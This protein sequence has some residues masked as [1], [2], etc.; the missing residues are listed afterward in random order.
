MKRSVK[1]ILVI[2][3]LVL[4]FGGYY[5]YK[6]YQVIMGSE[7]LTGELELIPAAM[8]PLPPVTKENA[9]WPNWRGASFEG[10][11]ETTGT[12]TDWSR[13]LKKLWQVNYLCQDKSTASWS[14][15]VVQGNRLIVPGRDEKN[16]LLFCINAD[17]GE[18]IWLGSYEAETG[19]SHGPG[20]RATPFISEDKVYSFGRSG[21]LVCWQLEDGKL[22]WRKNVK[23]AGGSEPS[24]GYSTTPLVL[25]NMVIVQGGGSAQVIAYDKLTGDLLWKSMEGE[26]GY[27]AA[28]TMNLDNEIKLLIYQGTGL[29][30]L[31]PSDG[32]VLWTVPWPTEYGVNATTPIV[33]DDIIFHTSGYKMGCEALKVTQN[34]YSILWKNNVMEAQHSDPILINGYIYGYSGESARNNG[35]FKCIELSTGKEMWS[36]GQI[37]Q[38]T[39]TFV[40]GHLICLDIKGNLFLIKPDP[41]GFKKVGQIKPAIRNVK[42]P[43]W[44]VPVVANGKLYLRYLQQLV[45]YKL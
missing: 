29:S 26:A 32:K 10:K 4:I 37:G 25:D 1:I 17:S 27:S 40:D 19:T 9:D 43:A 39:T 16:D 35:Q 34:G 20:P 24:W 15:P 11:N 41:S 38:G 45:C 12:Q 3:V 18:L 2:V 44:T 8:N 6:V 22:L 28:I 36:T 23:D 7:P 14:S 13:G 5:G 42:N 31:N 30:C 33:S 21:D